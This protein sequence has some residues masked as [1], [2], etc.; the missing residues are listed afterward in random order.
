VLAAALSLAII[1]AIAVLKRRGRKP[2]RG[3]TA[4][5]KGI[6]EFAR[7]NRSDRANR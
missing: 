6:E 7:E 4:A 5:N 3:Y 2:R 1:V